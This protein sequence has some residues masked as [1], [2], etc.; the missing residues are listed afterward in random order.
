MPKQKQMLPVYD[1]FFK[2]T[3]G[4]LKIAASFLRE[5]LP[6]KVARRLNFST[7]R[8]IT[9]TFLDKDLRAR[10]A[11]CLFEVQ[12]RDGGPPTYI[13]I[14]LEHQSRTEPLMAMR[15]AGYVTRL[16]EHWHR[17]HRKARRIPLVLP[18]IVYQGKAPW[19]ARQSLGEL[20][21]WPRHWPKAERFSPMDL[22]YQIVDVARLPDKAI[23]GTSSTRLALQMM[24]SVALGWRPAQMAEPLKLMSDMLHKH[25]DV[26]M[27]EICLRYLAYCR[28]TLDFD[29]L[30]STVEAVAEDSRPMRT[31][32]LTFA[33]HFEQKGLKEGRKEGAAMLNVKL[34][35]RRLGTLNSTQKRHIAGLSL[36]A[37][38]SLGME[39]LDFASKADLD[40][41]LARHPIRRKA[42]AAKIRR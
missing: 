13:Y 42:V 32:I 29:E 14:L 39:M 15:L 28:S 16:W 19:T 8:R 36:E 20:I 6:P 21:D 11:D 30:V 33:E 37:S 9:G 40:Q 17:S 24:K 22:V 35:E 23:R 12:S 25:E 10:Y 27:V 1:R 38:V 4:N 2:D 18:I 7:L 3:L 31:K 34:L 5:Y 41:W 26:D